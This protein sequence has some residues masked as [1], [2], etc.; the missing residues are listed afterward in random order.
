LTGQARIDRA[1]GARTDQQWIDIQ[2]EIA[3]ADVV[4]EPGNA[5]DRID[6][7]VER[8]RLAKIATPPLSDL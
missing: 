3:P 6:H 8:Q 2:F 5:H 7:G 4:C 1:T